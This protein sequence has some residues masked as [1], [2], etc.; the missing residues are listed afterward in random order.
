[1]PEKQKDLYKGA[2]EVTEV[3]EDYEEDYNRLDKKINAKDIKSKEEW[4]QRLRQ[5]GYEE[6]NKKFKDMWYEAR[7]K[8]YIEEN[9]PKALMPKRF[10]YI[11]KGK[12]V[13]RSVPTKWTTAQEDYILEHPKLK[14][15]ELY[16]MD[17]FAGRSKSSITSKRQ[18]LLKV[19]KKFEKVEKGYGK[20]G[21]FKT[22]RHW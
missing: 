14:P 6:I 9:A 18:R 16:K 21:R 8:K 7:I 17:V 12:P 3:A 2:T 5:T 11:R 15:K 10:R 1:M 19:R 22:R 13:Y 20:R 4:E